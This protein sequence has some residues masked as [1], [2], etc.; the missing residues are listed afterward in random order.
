MDKTNSKWDFVGTTYIL[1]TLIFLIFFCQI[2]G[3]VFRY[4]LHFEM[5]FIKY[6]KTSSMK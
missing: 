2:H 4:V 6:G 3:K 1:R 5:L